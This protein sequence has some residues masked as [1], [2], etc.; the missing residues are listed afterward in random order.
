MKIP[1]GKIVIASNNS[2]KVRE[3]NELLVPYGISTLKAGDFDVEEPEETE[4]T[5]K[6]NALLKA[7]YYAKVSG[8]PAL[9]DD[10]G[11]EVEAL[12][13]DPGIYSARWAETDNGRDFNLA[14]D[15]VEHELNDKGV[16]TSEGQKGYDAEKLKA[17]FTC[18]LAISFPEGSSEVFEGKVFGRLVFP[19]R[20]ERGF[21]YDPIFVADGYNITFGEMNPDEKHL[22]SHRAEAF[23]LFK[24]KLLNG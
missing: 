4:K 18:A 3:I 21:G 7:D 20:G 12:R 11:L 2:G 16:V 9:A 24:Q 15:R 22:I 1:Q 8:L 23:K 17:N 14:M 19:A 5:F 13:G 6:G 10:S